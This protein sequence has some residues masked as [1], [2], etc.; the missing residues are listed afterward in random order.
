MGQA[1]FATPQDAATLLAG[2]I[3]WEV[4]LEIR[5]SLEYIAAHLA[6]FGGQPDRHGTILSVNVSR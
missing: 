2:F 6:G 3:V 4:L 1:I 5:Q